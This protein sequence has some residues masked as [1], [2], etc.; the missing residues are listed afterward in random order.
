MMTS[1]KEVT[2]ETQLD[3]IEETL[4]LVLSKLDVMDEI[5]EGLQHSINRLPVDSGSGFSIEEY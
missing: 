3:R 4:A 2:G 1:S 5:I